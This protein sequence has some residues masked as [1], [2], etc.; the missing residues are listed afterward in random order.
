MAYVEG[1][2]HSCRQLEPG[3]QFVGELD[4][5]DYAVGP[6]NDEVAVRELDI[7]CRSLQNVRGDLLAQLDHLSRGFDD[8]GAAVHDR[9]RAS[10]AAA[11]Q[12]LVAVA[13][14]KANTI[15]RD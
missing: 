13:L 2:R 1:A 6:G 9:L 15:E 11:C 8:G 7:G 5:A 3:A 12:Q 4:D 14:C 10:G